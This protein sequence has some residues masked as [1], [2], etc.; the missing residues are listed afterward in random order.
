M[1]GTLSAVW[2]HK[3]ATLLNAKSGSDFNSVS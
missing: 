1:C 3:N 2:L